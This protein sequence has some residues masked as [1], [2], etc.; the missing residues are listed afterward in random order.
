MT[1]RLKDGTEVEVYE[2]KNRN[3]YINYDD[4]TTEYNKNEVTLIKK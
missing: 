1:I 3:T 2:S 4:C